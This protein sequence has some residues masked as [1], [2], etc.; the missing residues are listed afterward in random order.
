ME[1]YKVGKDRKPYEFMLPKLNIKIYFPW[2][3]FQ[4]QLLFV[5]PVNFTTQG[6][7]YNITVNIWYMGEEFYLSVY[8][9]S[10]FSN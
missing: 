3:V 2:S 8:C 4:F 1:I 7:F 10:T 5:A 6:R 9:L